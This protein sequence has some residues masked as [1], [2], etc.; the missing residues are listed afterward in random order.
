MRKKPRWKTCNSKC[1]RIE[2]TD[3]HMFDRK[4]SKNDLSFVWEA[5]TMC[6]C[7]A[8]TTHIEL[9][10]FTYASNS[11]S[12]SNNM[13]LNAKR[14]QK[15][16]HTYTKRSKISTSTSASSFSFYYSF[17]VKVANDGRKRT[18]N[19]FKVNRR[20]TTATTTKRTNDRIWA[21]AIAR[22][23]LHI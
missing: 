10:D 4:M 19:F 23:R 11:T 2:T 15:H 5:E 20:S 14:K 1:G 3:T 18:V 12:G 13:P 21:N 17:D 6:I 9:T 7:D 8:T 22:W 16:T